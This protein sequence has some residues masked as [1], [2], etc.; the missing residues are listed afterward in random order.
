VQ[1]TQ[2]LKFNQK[3][4]KNMSKDQIKE[5]QKESFKIKLQFDSEDDVVLC[6][7]DHL[8]LSEERNILIN[9]WFKTT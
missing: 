1:E 8:I 6:V 9:Y 2:P 7:D 3:I 5:D 4:F